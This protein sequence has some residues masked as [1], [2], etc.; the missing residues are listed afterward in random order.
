[1]PEH[2]ISIADLEDDQLESILELAL[3]LE[4]RPQSHRDTLR[5][6]SIGSTSRRRPLEPG[7]AS[8]RGWRNSEARRSSSPTATC[9]SDAGRRSP[10]PPASCLDTW[11][12]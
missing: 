1:M 6:K 8:K 10:T 3:Q 2:L 7:S 5:G 12:C 9:R 4:S 11:T